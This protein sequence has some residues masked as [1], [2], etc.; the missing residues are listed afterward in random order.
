MARGNIYSIK[1][2]NG[3]IIHV[4]LHRRSCTQT[5]FR[6]CIILTDDSSM[7][8]CMAIELAENVRHN[9]VDYNGRQLPNKNTDWPINCIL[10]GHV[11]RSDRIHSFHLN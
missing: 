11:D 8:Y 1:A 7:K 5:N 10:H 2:G 4:K 6:A 3:R 9:S